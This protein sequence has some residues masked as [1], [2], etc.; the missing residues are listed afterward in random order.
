MYLMDHTDDLISAE[1]PDPSIPKNQKPYENV[2]MHMIHSPCGH[3][4]PKCV[5]MNADK[6]AKEFPKSF[7]SQTV[8]K[9]ALHLKILLMGLFNVLLKLIARMITKY[10][11]LELSF[12]L[13]EV[14]DVFIWNFL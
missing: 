1:I 3:Y 9:S 8:L 5:C 11:L 6:C 12:I 10:V 14:F 7:S 2:I 4:N 13:N